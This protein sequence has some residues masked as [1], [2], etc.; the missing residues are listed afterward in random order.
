MNTIPSSILVVDHSK[1]LE[2]FKHGMQRLL[3]LFT[4]ISLILLVG[5]YFLPIRKDRPCIHGW[6]TNSQ[7]PED[8]VAQHDILEVKIVALTLGLWMK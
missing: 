4:T 5:M 6:F 3:L 8:L 7:L 1:I 2:I